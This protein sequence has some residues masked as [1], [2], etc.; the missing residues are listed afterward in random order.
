MRPADAQAHLHAGLYRLLY[1]EDQKRAKEYFTEAL[2]IRPGYP[3]A[4][5]F[6]A[7]LDE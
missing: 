3:E 6:L 5:S 4:L 1:K 7:S 2:R